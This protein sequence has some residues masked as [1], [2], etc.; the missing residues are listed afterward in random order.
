[1]RAETIHFVFAG[2]FGE[3][4]FSNNFDKLDING[5]GGEILTRKSDFGDRQFDVELTPLKTKPPAICRGLVNFKSVCRLAVQPLAH[6]SP[7]DPLPGPFGYHRSGGR[8]H[9]ETLS[10]SVSICKQKNTEVCTLRNLQSNR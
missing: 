10:Y 6:S 9:E 8:L 4:I 5:R 3:L 7:N 2:K 1:M